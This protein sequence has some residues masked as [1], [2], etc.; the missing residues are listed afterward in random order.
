MSAVFEGRTSD[1]PYIE[2]VWRGRVLQD[3][4]P[5]CPA[6]VR[7]NLLFTRQNGRVKV[8]A[9]GATTQ[10]VPKQNF[11]GAEFLVIKFKLGVFMPYLPAGNLVNA[12]AQL[13]GAA[14]QSFWLNG[15]AWDLPNF[16]N[17]EVFVEKLAREDLL[18]CDPVV[19]AALQDQSLAVSSRTVRRRF[20]QATGLTPKLVAQIERARRAASLLEQGASILDAAF[21]LGYADQPHLTRSLRRFYG[22]TPAQIARV[23]QLA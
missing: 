20:L 8:A 5:V 3:Y 6:D 1:S 15:F 18:H 14:S 12:D 23:T 13:P 19:D 9:E 10:F 2:Y 21:E 11:G 4:S 17:V 7:W 16:E 22:Q